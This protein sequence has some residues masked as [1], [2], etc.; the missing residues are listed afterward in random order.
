M[1]FK[2]TQHAFSN[3]FITLCFLH[4]RKKMNFISSC[5]TYPKRQ[6]KVRRHKI[7]P[8]S[9]L[10]SLWFFNKGISPQNKIFEKNMRDLA[11][12]DSSL[13]WVPKITPSPSLVMVSQYI[14]PQNEISKKAL[15]IKVAVVF[16]SKWCI[17]I[18]VHFGQTSHLQNGFLKCFFLSAKL[19][20]WG[21]GGA[22]ERSR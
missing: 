5:S 11:K 7:I 18:N 10:I 13:K 8:T 21:L 14:S 9:P 3:V 2:R 4:L 17:K 12:Q 16:S 1:R 15:Y 22:G 19:I 20:F 6:F